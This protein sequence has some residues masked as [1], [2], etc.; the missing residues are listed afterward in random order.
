MIATEGHD[1]MLDTSPGAE[2]VYVQLARLLRDQI[3]AGALAVGDA[4]PSE[5]RLAQEHGVNRL[6]ATSAVRLLRQ[7]GL[8]ATRK[9]L[10]TYV[11]A[12]PPRVTVE[13]GTG[14][15]VQA[16]MPTPAERSAYPNV[17]PGVPVI[18][19][20]RA[21]GATEVRSAAGL[22]CHVTPG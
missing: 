19:I 18:V 5:P 10:G 21:G 20:I 9:G 3:I 2:P 12:A 13:L 17:A 22:T 14:D 1:G 8:V 4:L 6:T 7:E 11:I 15:A 16:R